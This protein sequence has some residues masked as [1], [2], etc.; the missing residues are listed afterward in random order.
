M[1]LLITGC[2]QA[3][4]QDVSPNSNSFS[5]MVA[6][7]RTA[8]ETSEASDAQLALIDQAAERDEVTMEDL[9]D[10]Y[11]NLAVCVEG[12]GLGIDAYRVNDAQVPP[13]LEF[14][15]IGHGDESGMDPE[16]SAK[17]DACMQQEYDFVSYLYDLQPSSIEAADANLARKIPTIA[18]CLADRGYLIDSE[19]SVSDFKEAALDLMSSGD[20]GGYAAGDAVTQCLLQSDINGF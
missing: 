17:A 3:P 19:L 15:I 20:D 16:D 9:R 2:G 7:V 12:A 14:G 10:A 4:K 6:E 1:L 13:R 8:A 11:D 5:T 18:A